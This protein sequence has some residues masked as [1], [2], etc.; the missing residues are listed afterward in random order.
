MKKTKISLFVLGIFFALTSCETLKDPV[1][2]LGPVYPLSGQWI[3][4]FIKPNPTTKADTTMFTSSNLTSV[5]SSSYND[6][7]NSTTN[8]WVKLSG[9]LGFMKSFT[10]KTT[11]DVAGKSFSINAGANTVLSAGVSVGT[12]TITE[13]KVIL[14]GWTTVSG[15]KTDKITFKIED[16]RTPGVVY[17]AEGYR[18]TGWWEDEPM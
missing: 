6:A 18:K 5:T 3:I 4:R 16:S 2:E 13:G 7:N 15:Y 17:T 8:L 11:C 12:V 14:D 10:V 1:V 9:N